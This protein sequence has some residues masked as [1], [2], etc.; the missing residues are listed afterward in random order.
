[1]QIGIVLFPE[2]AALD[3][4]GPYEV[5]S[6]VPEAEVRF[7]AAEAGP[8]RAQRGLRLVADDSWE[9]CPPLEILLVPGGVGQCDL[10]EDAACLAFLRRQAESARWVAAVCTG[11]LLLGAAGLLEGYRA[12]THWR[13][14]GCLG[15]YGA[16]PV[17]KRVVVDRNRITAAGVSAGID[18]GLFLAALLAGEPA[19]QAIQLH[20]EYD[21]DP[22]FHAG[23]PRCAD[24]ELVE[25]V[26]EQT[27]AP[28]RR[29][30]EQARRYQE[31]RSVRR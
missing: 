25:Q 5:L 1:M 2:I 18:M 16:Q 15:H 31:A 10:T 21:P 28:Y 4:V 6:R 8:V 9:T 14:R 11:S 17:E 12:T 13:Y 30:L 19:A 24:A 22:P 26:E 27:L 20:L 7:V 29:R 23:S 3:V